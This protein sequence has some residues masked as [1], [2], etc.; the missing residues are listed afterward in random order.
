MRTVPSSSCLPEGGVCPGGVCLPGGCL[1]RG[2]SAQRGGVYRS[3]YWGRHPPLVPVDRIL[4]TRL[5]KY[6]RN[7][8]AD[9]NELAFKG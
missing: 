8:V 4:D 3:M 2:V 7:F 9:G 6:Y 5:W 1:L